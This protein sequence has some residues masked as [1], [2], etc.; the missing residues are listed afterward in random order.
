MRKELRIAVPEWGGRDAGKVFV[1]KEMSAFQAEKWGRRALLLLK[2][3][4]ARIPDNVASYGMAG[5]AIVGLNAFLQADIKAEELEP[6]M[7]EM[8]TC[9]KLERDPKHPGVLSDIASDDDVEE[10]KTL[11]WL[12]SEIIR[13]HTDFSPA[14]SLWSLI[15]EIRARSAELNSKSA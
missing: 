3:S 12:R 4:G 2:G 6:L 11:L 9:V 13:L 7:D 15:Q 1:I 5:V 10:V 8:L 14:D